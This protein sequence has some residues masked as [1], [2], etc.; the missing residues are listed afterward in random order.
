MIKYANDVRY[1]DKPH[2]PAITNNNTTNDNTN[3]NKNKNSSKATSQVAADSC[4]LQAHNSLS[5][6]DK[7]KLRARAS[8]RLLS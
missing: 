2:N 6:H 3:N 5:S 4:A 8:V 7:A 1:D